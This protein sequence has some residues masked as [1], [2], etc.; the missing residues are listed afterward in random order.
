MRT[1]VSDKGIEES[2][3]SQEESRVEGRIKEERRGEDKR[4]GRVEAVP[5]ISNTI[6]LSPHRFS[7]LRVILEGLE[8]G[9]PLPPPTAPLKT[10]GEERRE[11]K[12]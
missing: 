6:F 5:S 7:F 12:R 3:G 2:N 4:G 8:L 10:R 1:G 9:A 11:E